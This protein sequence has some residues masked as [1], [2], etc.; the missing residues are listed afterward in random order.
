MLGVPTQGNPGCGCIP[1]GCIASGFT[2][3]NS[4]MA[5]PTSLPGGFVMGSCSADPCRSGG[6]GITG[7]SPSSCSP[8]G[9]SPGSCNFNGPNGCGTA[10]FSL[11]AGS[12]VACSS[13]S[14]GN[15]CLGTSSDAA[16]RVSAEP[17]D[18]N[19]GGSPGDSNQAAAEAWQHFG[20]GAWSQV[21]STAQLAT[22]DTGRQEPVA[23]GGSNGDTGGII[24]SCQAG[25][26]N[27]GH[28]NETA[29]VP[30]GLPAG[31]LPQSAATGSNSCSQSGQEPSQEQLQQLTQLQ[32]L[33]NL[34]K[35][36]QQQQQQQ[37]PQ[38]APT[39]AEPIRVWDTTGSTGDG[40][41]PPAG[42]H[43]TGA[44]GPCSMPAMMPTWNGTGGHTACLGAGSGMDRNST[45][46]DGQMQILAAT[47][48]A[49]QM[50]YMQQ[51]QFY[52]QL[53]VQEVQR[54]AKTQT[55]VPSRF[56]E[57]FRPMRLCKHL[58]TLGFCR[59][60]HECTFGHT[61]DELHPASPDL[62]KDWAQ[63]S[64]TASTSM[65]A[66]QGEIPES[67]VPDM[68]LKKKKE[69]CGRFSRGECS[70]GKICPFAHTEAELGT[71]GLSVCGKVK[72]R[73]C[74]FWD[75]KSQTAKG[76][77]YGTNCNN[78]HGEREIGTKRPPPELAPPVKRRREGESVIAGRD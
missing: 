11:A 67:Q 46:D 40:S 6:C 56:K 41:L 30:V 49:Q 3:G 20:K 25:K 13:S 8:G 5:M 22:V 27:Q 4:G 31:A 24:G 28:A 9:Y 75:A 66:E 37:Q 16:G 59:Q 35:L 71:I 38:T 47:Q 51:F 34:Q 26:G 33:Q 21:G 73:L 42:G 44:V 61:Y 1:G 72:T 68:R 70:L 7:C 48:S 45:S 58:L 29:N 10:S 57:N 18:S 39:P 52:Q 32:H 36:Q 65:L 15:Q 60:G 19:P 23:G 69:M 74:V 78:A 77:I 54:R 50:Q 63:T 76:C 43:S 12:S 53:Q 55:Q 17:A 14:P 2:P 62:P 64:P